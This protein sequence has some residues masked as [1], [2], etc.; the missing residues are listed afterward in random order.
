MYRNKTGTQPHHSSFW[1]W[2]NC[3]LIYIIFYYSFEQG[4]DSLKG[5]KL[6]ISFC[7]CKEQLLLVYLDIYNCLD[8]H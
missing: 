5:I 7:I 1:L 8:F 4:S 6:Y 3:I 2:E